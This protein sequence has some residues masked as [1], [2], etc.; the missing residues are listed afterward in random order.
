M[1][2]H[3]VLRVNHITYDMCRA[4]DSINICN[5]PFIM[6][7]AHKDD[8]EVDPHLYWYAKVLGIYHVNMRVSDQ[9]EPL[10][11]DFLQVYWFRQDPDYQGG[12][13]TCR[14]FC[15]GLLDQSEPTSFGFINPSDILQGV[16]LIPAFASGTISRAT[17][18]PDNK[19]WEFYYV[20]IYWYHSISHFPHTDKPLDL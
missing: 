7:L 6:V 5:H 3:E 9:T 2:S 4:Q 8:T 18:D 16:Y 20:L 13:D 19:E 1:Y 11:M 15:I 17:G 10:R 14:P 12:F